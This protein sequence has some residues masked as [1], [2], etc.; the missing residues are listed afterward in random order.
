MA[1]F[2]L[3]TLPNLLAAGLAAQS[4][5]RF[6]RVPRARLAAGLAVVL[7][8]LIG[9]ARIPGLTEHSSTACTLCT[10]VRRDLPGAGRARRMALATTTSE[11]TDMP[12]AAPHGGR[13]PKAASGTP[14][15]L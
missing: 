7:L 4:L 14:R 6:L 1:A 11:L 12:R 5:G 10:E 8:G 15:R 3:G 9:L 2:G 13:S